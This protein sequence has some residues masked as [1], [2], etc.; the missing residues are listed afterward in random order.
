[1]PKQAADDTRPT[2]TR[3]DDTG[4]SDADVD[5]ELDTSS[6]PAAAGSARSGR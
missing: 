4:K 5:A 2:L 1:M 6:E 3:V